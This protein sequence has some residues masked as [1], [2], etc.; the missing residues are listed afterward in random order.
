MTEQRARRTGAF[1][2][3]SIVRTAILV[4][5]VGLAVFAFTPVLG[6]FRFFFRG[7]LVLGV[8]ALL[9]SYLWPVIRRFWPTIRR[10]WRSGR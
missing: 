3:L 8:V 4:V 2:R 1:S 7:I 9:G 6:P 10:A 5:V